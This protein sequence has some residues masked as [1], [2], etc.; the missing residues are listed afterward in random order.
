MVGDK[1]ILE[2]T[3]WYKMRKFRKYFGYFYIRTMRKICEYIEV[4]ID[5]FWKSHPRNEKR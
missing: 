3:S 1:K 5:G 2:E 4:K